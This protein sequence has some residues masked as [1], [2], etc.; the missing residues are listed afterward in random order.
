VE[1]YETLFGDHEESSRHTNSGSCESFLQMKQEHEVASAIR[2]E[3][4]VYASVSRVSSSRCILILPPQFILTFH[5]ACREAVE[6]SHK[7]CDSH[8]ATCHCRKIRPSI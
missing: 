2:D 7:V 4:R 6:V 5:R 3:R 1:P 8:A